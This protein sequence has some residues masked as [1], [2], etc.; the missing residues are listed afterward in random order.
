M[1]AYTLFTLM[2]EEE[3]HGQ[4]EHLRF[5]LGRRRYRPHPIRFPFQD[6]EDSTSETEAIMAHLEFFFSP[7]KTDFNDLAKL[8]IAP[9]PRSAV[10]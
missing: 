2:S 10:V 9:F 6:I 4:E 5:E 7:M 1:F 3:R 8:Y